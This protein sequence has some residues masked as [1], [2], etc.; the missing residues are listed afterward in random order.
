MSS[1]TGIDEIE[2]RPA[3][4]TGN[5]FIDGARYG[6]TISIRHDQADR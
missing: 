6:C 1:E 5:L 3:G 2:T 4:C